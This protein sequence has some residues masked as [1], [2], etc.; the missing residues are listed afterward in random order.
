[1][2]R[3]RVLPEKTATEAVA[4]MQKKIDRWVATGV[5]EQ[6]ATGHPSPCRKGCD[7]CCYHPLVVT[8]IEVWA[9]FEEL[10]TWPEREL[11]SLRY[12]LSEAHRTIKRQ[13]LRLTRWR[14]SA[15]DRSDYICAHIPCPFLVDHQCSVYALR[16]FACRHHVVFDADPVE[17]ADPYAQLLQIDTKEVVANVWRVIAGN[18][19]EPIPACA[20]AP[21]PLVVGLREG[22]VLLEQP[23]MSLRQWLAQSAVAQTQWAEVV[24]LARER[25]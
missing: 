9:L 12:R 3:L 21:V 11:A 1:M 8:L 20:F 14:S 16:P 10:R 18:S 24:A 15:E 13:R 17:C 4:D 5:E 2:R 23:A 22:M 25:R 7:H 19:Q 6:R